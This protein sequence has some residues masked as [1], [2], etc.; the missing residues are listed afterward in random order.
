MLQKMFEQKHFHSLAA[1]THCCI[2]ESPILKN[3]QKHFLLLWKFSMLHSKVL[4]KTV[5]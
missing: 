3:N 1:Q 4:S 2:S 5:M